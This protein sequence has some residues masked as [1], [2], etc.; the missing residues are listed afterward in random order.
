ML[1]RALGTTRMSITGALANEWSGVSFSPSKVV[2]GRPSGE[3]V[4]TWMPG[5]A[6]KAVWWKTSYGAASSVL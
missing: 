5:W 2:R 1:P 3:T 6:W 4:K